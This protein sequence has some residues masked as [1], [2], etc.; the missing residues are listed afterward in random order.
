MIVIHSMNTTRLPQNA[1]LNAVFVIVVIIIIVIYIIIIIIIIITIIIIII[2]VVVVV[3][4]V[5]VAVVVIVGG[6]AVG[7]KHLKLC[8][9]TPSPDNKFTTPLHENVPNHRKENN[10][11]SPLCLAQV[12]L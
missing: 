7:K 5:V 9:I 10:I 3:V 8:Y 12:W 11:Y 2:V 1:S 4:V 6:G